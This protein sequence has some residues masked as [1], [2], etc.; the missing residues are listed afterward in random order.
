[1]EARIVTQD[2]VYR[3]RRGPQ[4]D[5]VPGGDVRRDPQFLD[6]IA[7]ADA[8]ASMLADGMKWDQSAIDAQMDHGVALQFA[9]RGIV[10]YK[11]EPR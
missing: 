3:L 9:Y 7:T 8:M 1:V 10:D 4:A 5:L 11:W 2:R 6:H